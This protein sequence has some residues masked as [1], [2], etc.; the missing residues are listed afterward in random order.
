MLVIGA[1]VVLPALHTLLRLLISLRL[2][3]T[4]H[5]PYDLA[6]RDIDSSELTR[7]VGAA[8]VCL[9]VGALRR[10]H[11]TD[12]RR[13]VHKRVRVGLRRR[14]AART[15]GDGARAARG[16]RACEVGAA[17]RVAATQRRGV[18]EEAAG[19][20]GSLREGVQADGAAEHA[21]EVL[22]RERGVRIGAWGV[23]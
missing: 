5:K 17:D 19:E 4:T 2:T 16:R 3:R 8:W 1:F 15:G 7:S 23:E 12:M 6:H 14:R 11:E 9:R 18:R 21:E 10:G 20:V 13:G 22:G